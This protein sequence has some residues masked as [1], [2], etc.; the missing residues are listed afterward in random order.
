MADQVESV[1][2][3]SQRRFRVAVGVVIVALLGVGVWLWLTAGRESTDDAQ[4]DA[5]VTPIAAR[6]GGTVLRSPVVDN[7]QVDAGAILVELDP[8]DY[9]VA[10][11]K[12][13]AELANAEAD[14]LAAR[15]NV[16]IMSTTTTSNVTTAHGSVETARG[17][18]DHAQKELDVAHAR[19]A[20][21]QARQRE[22][23]ANATKAARD[24]ERLRGLLAKDEVSQQQFDATTAT[25]DAQRATGEA[26]KAQIA[27][28]EASIRAAEIR[29][30]Q[31]RVGEQ[32][33]LAG[34]RSAQTAPQQVAAI[35][36]RAA[37]ADA[38]AQQAKAALEQAELNL[39][40]TTIKAPQKGT[41]SRKSAEAGQVIQAGQPLMAL[42]P[43]DTVWITANFKETQLSSMRP[44]QSA[45][46]KVDAYGGREFKGKIESI[47]AA[48]GARFSLLPP[49]NATGN[50]VKVV[51]RVPVKIVLDAAQDPE[52]LLRPGMSVVP[53]VYTK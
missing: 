30:M 46:I 39:Q 23:Q 53:T 15:S 1:P 7:Q 24:V 49:E 9:Q 40:Y 14:A 3:T 36:A 4:V 41:I 25:A 37:A 12:A 48:T 8:R 21:A 19:L 20:S 42:V 51:Q 31:S 27:E 52:H 33:A 13:R 16:P 11:A 22:T 50:Y 6:V 47:A 43:L 18:V 28:A 35:E 17:D 5:H 38:H 10:V 26:A 34:L 44:G 2:L 32:N 45:T 29:L